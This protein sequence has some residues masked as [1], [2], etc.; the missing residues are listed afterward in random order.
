MAGFFTYFNHQTL[1]IHQLTHTFHLKLTRYEN[2]SDCI[3]FAINTLQ[4][5]ILAP[6]IIQRPLFNCSIND[7]TVN[8]IINNVNDNFNRTLARGV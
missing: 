6:I 2:I 7:L 4:G 8:I 3:M 1:L 5:K